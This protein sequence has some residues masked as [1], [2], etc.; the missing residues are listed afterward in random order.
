MADGSGAFFTA[1]SEI[2]LIGAAMYSP[3]ACEIAFDTVRPDHF[4]EPLYGRMWAAILEIHR[5]GGSPMPAIVR[6]RLGIDPAFE[7]WG[8][9][10]LLDQVWDKAT[11]GG[12]A[13]HVR[14]IIDR[15]ERREIRDLTTKIAEQISDTS[16]GDAATALADL[17]RGAAEIARGSTIKDAWVSAEDLVSNAIDWALNRSDQIE[18]PFGVADLD[19]FTGG[20]NAGEMTLLGARPGMGKTVGAQT[21]ART[22]AAAGKGVCFFSLEMAAHPL[23]LRLACDLAYDRHATFYGHSSANPTAD[24]AMRKALT[25]DQWRRLAESRDIVRGWPL[26]VDTRPG[27][28]MVHIE[29]AARRQ[30]RLW[31]RAGIPPGPVIIDHLGKVRPSKDRKGSRHAEMADVSSDAA[32]MAKRLGVPVLGLVQLNRGVESRED[33]RPTLSDLRQAGELEEDA[34]KVLFLYRPEY[35]LRDGP[36]GETFEQE[37]ERLTQ[38]RAVERELYWLVEKNSHGPKG[39]VRTFC[40]IGS[41]A[42]RSWAA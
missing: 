42:I 21:I 10:D 5:D 9:I 15:A 29:A 11:L 30:H 24:A 37:S 19:E 34:R 25:D 33:K 3:T 7:A 35:Y 6:D 31:D 28:T 16:L 17:E 20:L 32:E 39:Q 41:S 26:K 27:L 40:D 38:L 12:V 22:N 1:E 2:A 13:D 8:G 14:A 23:G 18:F 36:A 4:G